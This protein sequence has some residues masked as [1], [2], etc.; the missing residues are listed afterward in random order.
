MM[1]QIWEFQ[2]AKD[3]AGKVDELEEAVERLMMINRALW[4]I[5]QAQGGLPDEVL[6][7]KIKEIDLRD[8]RLDGKYATDTFRNCSKCGRALLRK[9]SRCLYCGT[10]AA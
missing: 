8:G 5:V 9:H 2:R 1:D 4:E 10:P 3:A 7:E 6:V